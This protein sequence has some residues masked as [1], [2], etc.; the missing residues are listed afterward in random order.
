[1]IGG[2]LYGISATVLLEPRL[3]GIF[4]LTLMLLLEFSS[5]SSAARAQ[6][7]QLRELV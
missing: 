2:I 7:V 4:I 5:N 1:M 6:S 3:L